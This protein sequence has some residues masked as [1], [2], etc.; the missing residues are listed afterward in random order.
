MYTPKMLEAIDRVHLKCVECGRG[1]MFLTDTEVGY[2][3]M[4]D[5]GQELKMAILSGLPRTTPEASELYASV[6]ARLE[7]LFFDWSNEARPSIDIFPIAFLSNR[8]FATLIALRSAYKYMWRWVRR[9]SLT[10]MTTS[11]TPIPR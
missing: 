11:L 9:V 6:E 2:S 10:M 4:A 8:F 7:L 3:M 5:Y 1:D